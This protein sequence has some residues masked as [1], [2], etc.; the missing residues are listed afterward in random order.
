[1]ILSGA[2][3]DIPQMFVVM[4]RNQKSKQHN[5]VFIYIKKYLI[6]YSGLA[7]AQMPPESTK[8][9]TIP[10]SQEQIN[11]NSKNSES[12]TVIKKKCC[13]ICHHK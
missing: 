13:K 7:Q 8:N 2:R 12:Q 6:L 4:I 10:S 11:F 9:S 3:A 5:Y 1:M